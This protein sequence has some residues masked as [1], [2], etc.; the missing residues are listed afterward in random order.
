V[1]QGDVALAESAN[2]TLPQ[3]N[4]GE[5]HRVKPQIFCPSFSAESEVSELP[6]FSGVRHLPLVFFRL[7]P[8]EKIGCLPENQALAFS[9]RVPFG[10]N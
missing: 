5:E 1:T 10:S 3:V 9:R 7:V 8:R 4:T 6:G 2:E